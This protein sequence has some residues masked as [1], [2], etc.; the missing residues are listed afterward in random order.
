MSREARVKVRK[1]VD[2]RGV[3]EAGEIAR[4]VISSVGEYEEDDLR[5]IGANR[6]TV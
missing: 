4:G 2:E 1:D 5:Y 6:A 3:S